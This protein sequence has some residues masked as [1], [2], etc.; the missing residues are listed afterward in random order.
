MRRRA[1]GVDP[2]DEIARPALL[3]ARRQLVRRVEGEQDEEADREAHPVRAGERADQEAE[4]GEEHREQGAH[5]EPGEQRDADDVDP[6]ADEPDV[7]DEDDERSEPERQ[8]GQALAEHEVAPR[9]RR[10]QKR[11]EGPA[12]ALTAERIRRAQEHDQ[13]ADRDSDL[14]R[15]VDRL[16]LLEEVER[17]VRRHEVGR[18]A[19][20]EAEGEHHREC[21]ARDPDVA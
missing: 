1:E 13:R 14:Q 5:R 4:P 17:L 21:A 11:L 9:H 3:R 7:R 10:Q 15:Q 18:D 16:A 6:A 20:Q 8:G 19:E 12:F 2:Q